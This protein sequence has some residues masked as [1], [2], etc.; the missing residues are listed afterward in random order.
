MAYKRSMSKTQNEM[1]MEIP[2]KFQIEA[3]ISMRDVTT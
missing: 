2:L 1:I 3:L